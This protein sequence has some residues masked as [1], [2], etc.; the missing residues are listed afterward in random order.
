MTFSR[1]HLFLARFF[2]RA[3]LLTLGSESIFSE[4]VYALLEGGTPSCPQHQVASGRTGT[5]MLSE[6]LLTRFWRMQA[7]VLV[8]CNGTK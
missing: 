6:L 8:V 3:A 5:P 7:N 2:W 1:R 4:Q